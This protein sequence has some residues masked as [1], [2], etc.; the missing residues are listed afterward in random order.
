V[1]TSSADSTIPYHRSPLPKRYLRG[2]PTR[3]D[4]LVEPQSFYD[5]NEVELLL[6][7]TAVAVEPRERAVVTDDDRRVRYRKLLIV[8]GVQSTATSG[9][10]CR[11]RRRLHAPQPRRRDGDL[12]RGVGSTRRGCG[13][14]AAV[15]AT[16]GNRSQ[17]LRLA[18]RRDR[19][20]TVAVGCD[21]L[22][23]SFDGKEE[24]CA[25]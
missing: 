16:G 23:Q 21:R 17:V 5:D 25:R 14:A 8:S 7:T 20:K 15:V 1:T 3:E 4:T 13:S 11:P 24:R 6:A 18:K 19:A 10:G 12:R 9:R 22:P 2:E